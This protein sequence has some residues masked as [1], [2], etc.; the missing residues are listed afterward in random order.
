M[1]PINTIPDCLTDFIGVRCL[2]SNPKSG[3]W[4]NDLPG[5][6]LQYAADIVD[7]DGNS[8]L[9]FLRDK[10]DF[11]TR[12]VL[13]E[14]AMA[15][16]PF[17]RINSIVDQIHVGEWA[18]TNLPSYSGDRGVRVITNKSRLL[19]LRINQVKV[20][21]ANANFSHGFYIDATDGNIETFNFTTDANGEALVITNFY[22]DSDTAYVLM[23][24]TGIS[25]NNSV[26]KRGCG[27][28]SKA[29]KHMTA[30]GWNGIGVSN[31][32]YGLQVD[33]T[34]ECSYNEL[35]CIISS[36]LPFLI[37]Y[38]AGIE[39]IKEGITSDR[40]NSMTLLDTDKAAYLI[41]DFTSEY[42]KHLKGVIDG[43]PELFKRLD[44]C[45]IV[46]NQSRYIIGKP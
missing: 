2:T 43:L 9:L 1:T 5:I 12:L 10:I 33:A 44:D 30:N 19:R 22:T 7:S 13:E 32:T 4:I 41:K 27:C 34:A 16:T 14:I 3:L 46:C 39:I 8:G 40:L 6:N 23:D 11:A 38:K 28:S 35:G 18:T 15:A 20:K 24:D 31:S 36:K 17:F 29:N 42:E 25:V 45:C 37:L 21:L 26:V